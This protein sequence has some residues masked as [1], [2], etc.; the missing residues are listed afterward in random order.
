MKLTTYKTVSLVFAALLVLNLISSVNTLTIKKTEDK[1]MKAELEKAS[2]ESEATKHKKHHKAHKVKARVQTTSMQVPPNGTNMSYITNSTFN[3]MNLTFVKQDM[4]TFK[5]L[6]RKWDYKLLDKQLE[7][8]FHDMNYRNES[9]N[10]DYGKKTFLTMFLNN[11]E[12]CDGNADNVL[13][14]TEF[15]SCMQNDTYLNKIQPP[16]LMHAA[17]ANYS[18]TNAT[19]FY[20]ILF[21]LFDSYH[22]NYTNLHDY[23]QLRLMVYSWKKCSV[24][25]PFIEE[26]SFEC[27]IEIAGGFKTMS[28]TTVRRLFALGLE[29]SNSESIRN[30]D[31]ITYIIIATSVRIYGKINGK[32]DSDI[33]RNEFNLALDSNIL[34]MRY[35]QDIINSCFKLIEE[36]DRPN[37]GMDV[38]S[39]VFYD[40]FLRIYDVQTPARQYYLGNSDFQSTFSNYLFPTK[41]NQTIAKIPQNVLNTSSYQMYSYVNITN[42]NNE[43]DHFLKSFVETDTE[44]L[45]EN[46]NKFFAK[47]Y[48]QGNINTLIVNNT[49]LTYKS[50]VT[51]NW[52]FQVLDNDADGWL[53][54]YD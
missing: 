6:N 44:V 35:N 37:Q 32:E 47:N 45:F 46:Q 18:F 52:I 14:I 39:F 34:P 24:S 38:I 40:F 7:D 12:A 51:L 11:F 20:P 8:I 23:M 48:N 25:A 4:N 2:A 17:F 13:N 29:L 19:G 15:T 26:V 16:P 33:T 42:Y 43:N 28:R 21:S 10:S 9:D 3:D 5:T 41:T 31:F 50:N 54:F 36:Y 22:F 27:A 1:S 53:N 49:N 30:M